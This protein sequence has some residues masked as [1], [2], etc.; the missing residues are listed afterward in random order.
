MN[1]QAIFQEALPII[2]KF[3][4]SIGEIIGGPIGLSVGYIIPILASA[5]NVHPANLKQL[6]STI[7]QD[8][9]AESKLQHIEKEH[10]DWLCTILNSVSA[11]SKAE[12]NVK[13]E[14]QNA[15]K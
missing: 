6:V 13:L 12:V 7:V 9:D 3:A 15:N 1:V 10:G 8:P 5:F 4:P 2:Q 14:W 11:L